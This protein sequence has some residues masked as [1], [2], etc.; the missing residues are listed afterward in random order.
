MVPRWPL[1]GRAEELLVIDEALAAGEHAGVVIAGPAGVGKTRL[2]RAA[3]ESAAHSGWSVHRVAG[4]A[5][6]RA[7]TLGAFARWVDDTDAS[8]LALARKV[9]AGL[10]A[11]TGDGRLLLLVDDAHLLDDLSALVVHQLVLQQVATVVATIRTGE[12]APDAVSALWKDGQLQRLELQPLSR[13]ETVDLLRRVLDGEVD[14]GCADRMWNLSRGNVLFLRHLVEYEHVSGALS[15]VQGRWCWA[16]TSS[17]SPSLI[18]LVDMQIGTV[19]DD[20]REVVDLVAI[21]EPV[22]RV[23]L[24]ALADQESIED[25]EQRGLIA[26][27]PDSDS[28]YVGHPL[29]GE[30]RLSQCGPLRLRRLRGR[31]ATAMVQGNDCEPLRLGLLWLE[32][33]LPPDADILARAAGISALRLDFVLAERLARAAVESQPSPANKL[34]LAHILYLQENGEAV[35]EILNS[36]DAQGLAVPGFLDGAIIRAAN[37]LL[38]LRNPQG[39]RDVLDAALN[40]GD[41]DRNHALRTFRAVGCAMAAEHTE[42]IETMTAVDYDRLDNYG[43]VVG[44]AAETLALGDL[45]RIDEAADRARAGHRVLDESPMDSFHATGLAEFHAYALLAA[46]YLD[47]AVTVAERGYRRCAELPGVPRSM[48]VAAMGMTALAKGDLVT[49]LRQFNSAGESLGSYGQTSGL[50]Y[51]FRILHTE[52]L[53][54][55]GDIDGAVASL[56]DVERSRHPSYEYVT[57]DYLLAGAWVSA[58]RGRTAE[59]RETALHAAE[60]ARTHGQPAREVRCLQTAVQLGDVHGGQRLAELVDVVQGPRA[61]LAHRYAH[62]LT[63]DD[64]A[65]LDAVSVEFEQ[66]GDALAAA[67]AAAQAAASHRVTGRRGSALTA[68]ARACLLAERCGGAVSPALATARVPLPFTRREH[69]IAGL[70]SRGL[71]NRDIAAATSLSIR[72]VEGHIYQASV[73]AGVSSRSEL[74]DLVQQ[75]NGLD[76]VGSPARTDLPG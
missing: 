52:A 20:V 34:Q 1:T 56:E 5:T 23:V 59:A 67:D 40:C 33:D 8:P 70:L 55:S 14:A 68:S 15:Q 58:A 69:E 31:A 2:A 11:H 19:P 54:R 36:L 61:P 74:S 42:V 22:D 76:S 51:R 64:A 13:D 25:A 65:A 73:K 37:L 53:A 9:F 32:S 38:P 24:A 49:A 30:I 6:G 26:A 66:M 45:G 29:Y 75:F 28:I 21:T 72:T 18:E 10:T 62:A 16:A 3:A 39:S 27:A 71:S 44:Y 63:A 43:R 35:E 57:S 7:V 46:G 60:F 4:T 41:D 12:S 50:F 17:V 47:E 48:A